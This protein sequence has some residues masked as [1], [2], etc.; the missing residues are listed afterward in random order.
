MEI[1]LGMI[2]ISPIDFWKMSVI[3]I[4]IAIEGFKEFHTSEEERPMTK[5]ELRD[6]MEL[7][8]D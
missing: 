8:P 2:G 7:H 1:C 5:N 3:E 6:L 4:Y